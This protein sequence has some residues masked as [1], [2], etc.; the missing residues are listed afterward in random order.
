MIVKGR[1]GRDRRMEERERGEEI[2][3]VS[4]TNYQRKKRRG[5]RRRERGKG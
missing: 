1:G 5:K 2:K 3:N 4:E